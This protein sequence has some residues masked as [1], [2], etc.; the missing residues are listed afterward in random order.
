MLHLPCKL[1][2]DQ[3]WL[4][5]WTFTLYICKNSQIY[6]KNARKVTLNLLL[7]IAWILYRIP[8][9]VSRYLSKYPLILEVI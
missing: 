2:F 4:V 6:S 5:T 8:E 1:D 7:T 9:G 3:I